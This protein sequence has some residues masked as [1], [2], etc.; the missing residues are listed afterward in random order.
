MEQQ[1][2]MH[3]INVIRVQIMEALSRGE[4]TADPCVAVLAGTAF[5]LF[6]A[7]LVGHAQEHFDSD[8]ETAAAKL[9]GNAKLRFRAAQITLENGEPTPNAPDALNDIWFQRDKDA[10][11]AFE[12][13]ALHAL[14]GML[15]APYSE[16]ASVRLIAGGK[17]AHRYAMAENFLHELLNAHY[18]TVAF[19]DLAKSI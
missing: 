15:M 3:P 9:E 5:D 7:Q 18:P 16:H 12:L 11:D 2:A 19:P 8:I 13:L 14:A 10:V 1:K 17:R 6:S 4:G